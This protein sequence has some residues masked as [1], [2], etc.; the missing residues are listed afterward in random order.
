[1]NEKELATKA[2]RDMAMVGDPKACVEL[3]RRYETSTAL[4]QKGLAMALYWILKAV[5]RSK[6]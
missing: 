2:L 5:N 6:K 1:M 3:A 4:S